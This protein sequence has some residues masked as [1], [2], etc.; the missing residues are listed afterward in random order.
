MIVVVGI[1]AWD[2]EGEGRPAGRASEIASAAASA[3]SAVELVGRAGDDDAGDALLLALAGEGVGHVALLRDPARPTRL[4]GA[5][6]EEPELEPADVELGLRYLP[7][8]EVLVVCDDAPAS[9]L[10][11]CL[12]GASFAG[13]R[14]VLAVPPERDATAD[15]PSDATLL[16]APADDDGSFAHLVGRYAAGLDRGEEPAAAFTAATRDGWERVEP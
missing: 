1:P 11:A 4:I 10:P 2:A 14:V 5:G 7:G 8:F 9:I 12:D 3:G 6:G 16:V 15:L 13:A